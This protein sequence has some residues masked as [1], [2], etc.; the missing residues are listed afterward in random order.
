MNRVKFIAVLLT[1][2]LL[3]SCE[4]EDAILDYSNFSS[5]QISSFYEAEHMN[6]NR[7]IVYYYSE[8]CSHCKEVKEEILTLFK[9]YTALDFYLVDVAVASGSSTVPEFLGTPTVFVFSEGKVV[10]SYIGLDK[11]RLFI[12]LNS[13]LEVS[14]ASFTG[15][16]FDS[17]DEILQMTDSEYIIYVYSNDTLSD[18]LKEEVLPWAYQKSVTDIY[19]INQDEITGEIPSSLSILE[20]DAPMIVLMNGPV[21]TDVSY[22]GVD[23]ILDYIALVGESDIT[24]PEVDIEEIVYNYDDF[25]ENTITS[26]SEALSISNNVH[27]V[28]FY[29]ATCGH[30]LELKPRILA[31]FGEVT[32]LEF[33]IIEIN[34][35]TRDITIPELVGVPTLFLVVDNVIVESYIGTVNIANFITNYQNGT[36]DLTEY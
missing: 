34:G 7:Y 14:Y 27:V 8:N 17:Y 6:N 15:R 18:S 31:F 1:I 13:D 10:E 35:A 4:K 20:L 9:D 21:Y 19:F 30:C 22:I 28:Y 24:T 23:E 3:V 32:D 26:Y 5:H 11:V 33:F 36:L 29:S 2:L 25:A 16:T 12:M